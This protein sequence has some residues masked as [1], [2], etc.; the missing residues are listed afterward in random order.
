MSLQP[1]G[2]SIELYRALEWFKKNADQNLHLKYFIRIVTLLFILICISI[3]NWRQKS[4]KYR[5]TT[6]G[7]LYLLQV[8]YWTPTFPDETLLGDVEVEHVQ[9]VVDRLDLAYLDEPDLDVLGG[10]H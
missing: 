8:S 1:K 9:R 6:K 3:V 4:I 10:R 7:H 2:E 5:S